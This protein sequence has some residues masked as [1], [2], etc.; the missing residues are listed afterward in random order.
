MSRIDYRTP[1]PGDLIRDCY[2]G[3]LGI[4]LSEP[5]SL[6]A[7]DLAMSEY[8]L[9][10]WPSFEGPTTCMMIAFDKGDVEFV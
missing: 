7:V 2:D 10:K 8:V 5:R 3:E 6:S 1:Q 9:V 4:V